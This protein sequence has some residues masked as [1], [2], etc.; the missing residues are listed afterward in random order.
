M[1]KILFSLCSLACIA[2]C[3]TSVQEATPPDYTQPYLT[4]SA[5]VVTYS[6]TQSTVNGKP[7]I[8][9]GL[10]GVNAADMHKVKDLGFNLVQTY[11]FFKMSHEKQIEYLDSARYNNM[12]VFAGLNGAHDLSDEHF[13]K[14]KSTVLAIK[15][16][17][18]LYAWYLADEP[19]VKN[20]TP[21]RFQEVY[22][23]I[24]K[25]DP[26]H[27]VINSNWEIQ[28]FKD[29]CDAD[30]RQLYSGLPYRQTSRLESYL[31]EENK[32][33]KTWVAILNAYDS[34]W[35]EPG[36]IGPNLNP[37]TAFDKLAAKGL[38][39]GD[40]EWEKEEQRWQPLLD[41][42]DNP[43]AAGFHTTASFPD[44]PAGVRG[45]I[46][47]AFVH[48]SNGFYYWL[49]TNPEA[50]L[51]LRWGWY[52]LFFQPQL[53]EAVKSTLSEIAQLSKFLINPHLDYTSFKDEANPGF[54]VWSKCVDGK[55]I[56]IVVNESGKPESGMTVDLSPLGLS[57]ES[58]EV[59]NEDGRTLT[60]QNGM[61]TDSFLQ[62]E[63]HVYF[64]K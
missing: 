45:S 49:Y 9:M 30:M 51:N 27:P 35:E 53:S 23:W 5:S 63:A 12:M 21:E 3:T 26:N 33:Q 58:L 61:L 44:T 48:G 59:F 55:R 15:D 43:A 8:P 1:K 25:T 6:Q 47:W 36:V 24:K 11:G 16:H 2:S 20:V 14:I 7:F 17:P 54:F 31:Y 39:N 56:V 52:T 10:Y 46:Y 57:A 41:N 60:L 34:G 50:G 38:K 40:P 32:G 28:N 37:T 29:A 19:S 18:A 64:V 4:D 62:D 42:L 13:G 22:D